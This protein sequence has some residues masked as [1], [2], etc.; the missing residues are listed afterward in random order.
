MCNAKGPRTFTLKEGL[1]PLNEHRTGQ[2]WLACS[3]Q[4]QHDAVSH[5][6]LLGRHWRLDIIWKAPFTTGLFQGLQCLVHNFA[7]R[8]C[9]VSATNWKAGSVMRG[10]LT[11]ANSSSCDASCGSAAGH[12]ASGVPSGGKRGS[13]LRSASQQ[14]V[15][16]KPKSKGIA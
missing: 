4:V 15:T 8:L 11:C 14:C 16:A 12:A 2:A 13:K 5:H 3:P 6:Q 10:V 1:L 9:K 7:L